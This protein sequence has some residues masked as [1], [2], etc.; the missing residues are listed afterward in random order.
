MFYIIVPLPDEGIG[1]YRTNDIENGEFEFNMLI[2]GKGLEDP[3]P[4]WVDDKC[5]LAIAFAKSRIG[6]NSCIGLYEVSPDLRTKISDT[7]TIIFDGHNTQPTIEGP[8]F[9]YRNDYFYILAPAGSVKTGWQTALRSKNVY[10]PYEEKIIMCQNDSKINGPHQGALVDINKNQ[11]VFIHFQD[12]GCYGRICHLQPVKW[13]NDWPLIGNVR[14]DLL[15]GTPVDEYDYFIDKKSNYK[16]EDSDKF[17]D[18]LSNIWQKPANK[19]CEFY[20]VNNGLYLYAKKDFEAL[21]KNPNTLLAKICHLNFNIETKFDLSNLSNNS[22]AGLCYMG[23]IYYY[24]D[25]INKNNKKYIEL[26][27]GSFNNN[28][29]TLE[30]IEYDQNEIIFNMKFRYPGNYQLG[31]NGKYFKTKFNATPGRWIGG[32]YGLFNNG[33]SGSVKISYFKVRNVK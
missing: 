17:I 13:V 27:Q 1:V 2:E 9:Y 28:D 23:S 18:K 6:F 3:C 5:Y 24:I 10:G 15:N 20:E 21:N 7:Y 32:K 12:L 26:R 8:K 31:Y 14:D 25:V 4:I 11:D 16:L 33:N 30:E 22:R 29:I 19:T